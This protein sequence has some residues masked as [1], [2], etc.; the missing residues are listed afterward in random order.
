MRSSGHGFMQSFCRYFDKWEPGQ[1]HGGS[2]CN[3]SKIRFRKQHDHHRQ[4]ST[5]KTAVV[6]C[7]TAWSAKVPMLR[8]LCRYREPPRPLPSPPSII[9]HR[10]EDDWRM[11]QTLSPSAHWTGPGP[12]SRVREREVEDLTLTLCRHTNW[13]AVQQHKTQ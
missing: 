11:A 3:R 13:V 5:S 7:Y 1:A 6:N 10:G 12:C 2:R 8:G 9:D 4:Q